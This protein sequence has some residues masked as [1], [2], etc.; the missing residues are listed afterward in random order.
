MATVGRRANSVAKPVQDKSKDADP[1]ERRSRRSVSAAERDAPFA[2][3]TVPGESPHLDEVDQQIVTLLAADARLSARA[4]AREIEMSP[5]AV[6]ERVARLEAGGVIQG[7]HA[8]INPAAL[9]VGMLVLIGLR[10]QQGSSLAKTIDTL[11]SIPEIT[12]VHVVSGQWDMVVVAQ[13]RDH[14]HL[15]AL[16]LDRVWSLSAFR[17]SET[18]LVLDSFRRAGELPGIF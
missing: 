17:H 8:D 5:G 10:T 3:D 14:H 18:M 1:A 9:G 12:S 15:R 6:S 4:V 7:Y 13:V 16:V 2:S 11:L